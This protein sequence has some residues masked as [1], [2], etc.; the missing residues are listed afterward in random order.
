M[1]QQILNRQNS[2][3]QAEQ[4][5]Q[6]HDKYQMEI[7]LDY[8]LHSGKRTRYQ[9]DT[10]IFIP[11]SLGI[12][13]D[14]Y[15]HSDFYTDVQ[16]YVRLKTPTFQLEEILNMPSSPLCSIATILS[17][18]AWMTEPDVQT[19][20]V[21]HFKFLRAVLKSAMWRSIIDIRG[22]GASIDKERSL[23]IRNLIQSLLVSI[24]KITADYRSFH[25]RLKEWDRYQNPTDI[26]LLTYYQLTDES[27]SLLIEEVLYEG[28]RL[29]EKYVN[30]REQPDLLQQVSEHIQS[31]IN[32]RRLQ[33]YG[34][35]LQPGERNEEYIFRTSVL[36]KFTSSILYL[37]TD[38]RR[39]GT[40]LE[41]VLFALAAGFA[42]IFATFVAFYFQ[43]QFG[44]FT[45]P[46]FVALVVG[47]MFKDRI[48]EICRFYF[49]QYL[50]SK[51]HD[52][53]III[54][55]QDRQHQ[56]GFMR[57]KMSFVKEKDIPSEVITARNRQLMTELDNDG[58]GEGVICY[59][60]DVI[61]FNDAIK[62]AYIDSPQIPGIHDILRYDVR[63]YLRKMANP[64]QRKT[65]LQN[66]KLR[67]VR[68]QKVYYLNFISVYKR[69]EPTPSVI[70]RRT[71]V[72]LNRKGIQRLTPL[73]L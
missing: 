63:P 67:T 26:K 18:S 24:G 43:R 71:L 42:M 59:T 1:M 58:Q 32:Y 37:S 35:M 49:S 54:R 25:Q 55:T 64:T 46:L 57:E 68:C 72:T 4:R 73:P 7:K 33:G 41:H 36:K 45:Y 44:M 15:S 69:I 50:R 65:H 12:S 9:I 30:K 6:I 19:D 11:S 27:I 29:T 39:E 38:I 47:Y 56:L 20:L 28:F 61:L 22:I 23:K 10:Y 62:K 40:T 31:E 14:T 53:R 70:C 60:K 48:K 3:Q 52:R 2:T 66:G 13:E 21:N 16:N 51:L 34:S 17:D 5:V 8:S